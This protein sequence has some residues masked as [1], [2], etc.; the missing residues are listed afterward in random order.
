MSEPI[1]VTGMVLSVMPMGEYDRRIVLLTKERGKITAFAR[2][3]RKSTS[4]LLAASNSFAFGMFSLYE[5]RST[6]TLTK[7]AIRHYFTELA[8]AQPEIYYGYYFLEF[9]GYYGREGVDESQMLNLLFVALKALLNERLDNEL[10]KSVFELKAM[11][12][13]GEYPQLFECQSC[14]SK[15]ALNSFSVSA[16]GMICD[17]CQPSCT[18]PIA[19]NAAVLYTLR[20]V[21]TT[22]LDK[23]YTFT[24]TDEVRTAVSRIM[25]RYV[26]R[27]TDKKFKT[28]EILKMMC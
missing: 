14:G 25:N 7:A 1:T 19:V 22:P 12:I 16:S 2:G 15:A 26:E 24:V 18:D 9:A 5:G 17:K 3:A 11:V 27:Y 4:A 23:L 21:V 28:L 10:I 8:Q 13:N 6:Y 20:F